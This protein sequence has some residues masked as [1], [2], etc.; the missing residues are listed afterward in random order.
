MFLFFAEKGAKFFC[1]KIFSLRSF[2]PFVVKKFVEWV[3][4]ILNLRD[5]FGGQC[6]PCLRSL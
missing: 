2:V 6:P 4:P 3:L 5:I 1:L